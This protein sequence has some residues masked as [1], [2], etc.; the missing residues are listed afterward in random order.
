MTTFQQNN[1]GRKLTAEGVNLPQIL[2]ET[3]LAYIK[4]ALVLAEGNQTKAEKLLSL[5]AKTLIKRLE[6][7]PELKLLANQRKKQ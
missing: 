4:K 5:G 1:N 7:F 2:D 6:K 3:E